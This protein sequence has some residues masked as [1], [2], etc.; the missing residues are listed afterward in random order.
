[1]SQGHTPPESGRSHCMGHG[2]GDFGRPHMLCG[3]RSPGCSRL[4][5]ALIVAAKHCHRLASLGR[6]ACG[7][8]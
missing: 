5:V 7:P 6:H 4:G 2:E 1:M 8:L 3:G